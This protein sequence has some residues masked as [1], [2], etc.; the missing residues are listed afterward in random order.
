ME[1]KKVFISELS[2]A[3]YNPR[4]DLRPGDPEFESIR[5]S[6]EEYGYALP[7]KKIPQG[8][9]PDGASDPL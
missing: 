5:K 9:S 8:G 2:P 7:G 1:L 4:K 3:E 6:I